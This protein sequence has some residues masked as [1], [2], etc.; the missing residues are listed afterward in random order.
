[1]R[2]IGFE[3]VGLFKFKL[4]NKLNEIMPYYNQLYLSE[5]MEFDPLANTNYTR[6]GNRKNEANGNTNG[7]SKNI[8]KYSETPQSGLDDV[9][10]GRYLTTA[11]IVD[12]TFSNRDNSNANE[13]YNETIKGII[14]VNGSKLLQEFRK[15]MLNIDMQIID[16][17]ES[18]F[19]QLW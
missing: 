17:L 10:T 1:M 2:E 14:G 19:I 3:T 7:T 8:D 18:L 6:E 16:E 5:R 9:E 15:T 4:E 13:D 11:D 12:N